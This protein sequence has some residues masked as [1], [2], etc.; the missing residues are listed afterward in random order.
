MNLSL[1]IWLFSRNKTTR[2]WI[3]FSILSY[4]YEFETKQ[5]WTLLAIFKNLR[6]KRYERFAR[7]LGIFTNLRTGKKF[8]FSQFLSRI[9]VQ[10]EWTSC[11]IIGYFQE[12]ETRTVCTYLFTFWV[13]SRISHQKGMN[14]L[15]DFCLY[16]L[17]WDHRKA[18]NL[19]LD[20]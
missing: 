1:D 7:F 5:P 9:W 14:L 17:I 4:F 6:A 15:L 18:M 10:K 3:Y 11:S 13:F 20:F 12:L 2:K 19:L 16:L 8:T